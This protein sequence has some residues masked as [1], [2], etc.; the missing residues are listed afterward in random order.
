MRWKQAWHLI[1]WHMAAYSWL[2][3]CQLGRV[4]GMAGTRYLS[5]PGMPFQQSRWRRLRFTNKDKPS[6]TASCQERETTLTSTQN[7]LGTGCA[8][9]EQGRWLTIPV[10]VLTEMGA[11]QVWYSLGETVGSQSGTVLGNMLEKGEK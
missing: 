1:A 4:M 7:H 8:W 5:S 6:S 10:W 9:P 3:P 2:V 11:I